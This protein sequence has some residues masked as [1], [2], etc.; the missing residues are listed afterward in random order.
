M[1]SFSPGWDATYGGWPLRDRISEMTKG[2]LTY[3]FGRSLPF[4]DEG[5][6]AGH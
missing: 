1:G 5:K 2:K 3:R 6:K 4:N